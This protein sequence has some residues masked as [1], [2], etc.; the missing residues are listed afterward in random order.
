MKKQHGSSPAPPKGTKRE[1]PPAA[2]G[3][4]ISAFHTLRKQMAKCKD[5]SE[6][7]ARFKAEY[8]AMG[9]LA[10]YQALSLSGE[11]AGEG[12]D[13]SVWVCEEL[14][15]R[16]GLAGRRLL[17]V[18]AIRARYGNHPELAEAVSID[19]LSQDAAVREV[20]FFDY[21]RERAP[22]SLDVIVLSLVLNFVA[23]PEERGRMLRECSRL[24]VPGGLLFVV[25]PV[26][27]ISNSRYFKWGF[28]RRLVRRVGLPIAD[29]E[30][31]H[32]SSAQLFFAVCQ[33]D[34]SVE[35]EVAHK[36]AAGKSLYKRTVCRDGAAR[37]NFC[38]LLEEPAQEAV[39]AMPEQPRAKKAATREKKILF[40]KEDA[41]K[42]AST[43]NQRKKARM[44]KLR[45]AKAAK[46]EAVA[47]GQGK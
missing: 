3:E 9:G 30:K 31:A 6:E 24:L 44:R 10:A 32:K 7:L 33:R 17:D 15:K 19:L 36:G 37:N 4:G 26:A 35:L 41:P 1:R 18:G 2:T 13:A 39:E 14:A 40:S 28:F 23:T 16:G 38:I 34:P 8:E 42:K 46:K 45:E 27:A 43:S 47:G 25:L 21:C 11:E 29:Q 5:N 20:D 22:A 12:F